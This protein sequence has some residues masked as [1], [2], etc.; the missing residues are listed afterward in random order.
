MKENALLSLPITYEGKV[1]QTTAVIDANWRWS[2]FK[3]NYDN[4]FTDS[5]S[6]KYCPDPLT[7]SRNCVVEG[8]G[9]VVDYASTYGVS[10]AG[11]AITLR[12]IT[13]HQYGT[14]IGSRMYLLAPDGKN[15]QGFNLL[16]REF[17]F[18]ADMSKTECG[19]NG[20]IY[21]VE[22]PLDGNFKLNGAGAPYGTAY[23]DAQMP[24]D[25]KYIDGWVNMNNTGAASNEY[26]FWEA[27]KYA[28]AYT[29]HTCKFPGVKPCT[30]NVDCGVGEN[31]FKGWCDKSGADIN[32]Y[33]SDPVNNKYVYGPGMNYKVDT[34][35]PF[36]V[37]TQ[38]ITNDK[39]DAGYLV[40]IKRFYKQDGKIIDGGRQTD[41]TIA[42]Q[43]LRFAEPNNFAE[44]GGLKAMGES[45]RRKMVLAISLWDDAFSEN[46][47]NW[48]DSYTG[49]GT[50]PGDMR[51][52]CPLKVS[53]SELRSKYP[54]A[55][56]VYSDFQV[57]RLSTPVPN[58][59][60]TPAENYWKCQKCEWVSTS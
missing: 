21:A 57:N 29:G 20:A 18:T 54:A 9:S 36:Q 22:M 2:R 58:P 59:T 7:C 49:D 1:I 34:T 4:C 24:K 31:R 27:N 45:F 11:N 41:A 42:A 50:K 15:Y 39:T 12:Y 10:T 23:G 8:A 26:D 30:N 55:K 33:R 19:L 52:P 37:I 14:N 48:L 53:I 17:V 3:D 16:N 51:G 40:E 35:R 43:N 28:N 5:W 32:L 13:T 25:V 46:S 38:F 56:V 44:L 6:S 60:S 47:M